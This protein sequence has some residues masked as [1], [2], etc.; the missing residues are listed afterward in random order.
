MATTSF[1]KEFVVTDKKIWHRLKKE[2]Y[3]QESTVRYPK[4]DTDADKEKKKIY[5]EWP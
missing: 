1:K 3:S 5:H 2:I 4:K